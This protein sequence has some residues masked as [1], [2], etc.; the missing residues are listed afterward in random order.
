MLYPL[1]V[2]V[3]VVAMEVGWPRIRKYLLSSMFLLTILLASVVAQHARVCL[4]VREIG[5]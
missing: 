2:V 4:C 5:R 3:V 1:S